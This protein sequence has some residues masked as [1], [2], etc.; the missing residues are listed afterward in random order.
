[1]I[2]QIIQVKKEWK[3]YFLIWV[4]DV[5]ILGEKVLR[6]RILCVRYMPCQSTNDAICEIILLPRGTSSTPKDYTYVG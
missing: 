2:S 3:Q 6:S 5:Y 1:M 4:W